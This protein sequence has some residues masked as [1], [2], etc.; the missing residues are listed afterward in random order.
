M[1][2]HYFFIFGVLYILCSSNISISVRT[3]PPPL[4]GPGDLDTRPLDDTSTKH[5]Y[6]LIAV[7]MMSQKH[8]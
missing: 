4:R 7:A 2:H 3:P 6:L 8:G 1:N 5:H